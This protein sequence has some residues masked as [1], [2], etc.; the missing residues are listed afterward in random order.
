MADQMP[1]PV[2]VIDPATM[3]PGYKD[4]VLNMLAHS[5]RL[6]GTAYKG[7]LRYYVLDGKVW[8]VPTEPTGKL[9][10]MDYFEFCA[11]LRS[12]GD[13]AVYAPNFTRA[14][15]FHLGMDD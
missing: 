7:T 5:G 3:R 13:R 9:I 2:E 14:N 12:A 6:I 8:A 4:D 1:F 15:G 11:A 10:R